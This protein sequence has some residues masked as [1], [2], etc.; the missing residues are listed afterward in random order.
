[1]LCFTTGL[2]VAATLGC[3]LVAGWFDYQKHALSGV[4]ANHFAMNENGRLL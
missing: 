3:F 1:V 2:L 4:P